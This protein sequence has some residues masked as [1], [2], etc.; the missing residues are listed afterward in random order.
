MLKFQVAGLMD[1]ITVLTDDVTD[2]EQG[3]TLGE[4]EQLLQNERILEL[5]I[6]T[7]S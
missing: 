3:L 2:V 4:T 5:E 1:D 6:D 7:N